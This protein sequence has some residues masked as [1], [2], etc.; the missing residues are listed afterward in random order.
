MV[1]LTAMVGFL[2]TGGRKFAERAVPLPALWELELRLGLALV[3]QG[4]GLWG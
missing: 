3:P 1:G 2:A 4:G